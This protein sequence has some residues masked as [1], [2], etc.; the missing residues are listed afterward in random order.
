MYKGLLVEIVYN[1]QLKYKGYIQKIDGYNIYIKGLY[2]GKIKQHYIKDVQIYKVNTKNTIYLITN[3]INNKKYVGRTIGTIKNRLMAHRRESQQLY[4]QTPLHIDIQK[5]GIGNFTI[6]KICE[7]NADT[8]KIANKTEQ[9]YIKKYNT[10]IPY[11][12]NVV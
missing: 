12:Y 2:D 6:E 5:Y 11:G 4:S 10:K 3:K 9:Y 1:P 7:F 8:Q